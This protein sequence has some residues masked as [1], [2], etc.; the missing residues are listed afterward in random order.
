[1]LKHIVIFKLKDSYLGKDKFSLAQEIKEALERLPG[2]IPQIKF[3]EVGINRLDDPRAYDLALISA[4]ESVD[5]LNIYRNHPEHKKTLDFIL[6][7]AIDSKVV[8]FFA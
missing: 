5:D 2:L 1:M 6:E 7:R 8:D 4:F 3:Y